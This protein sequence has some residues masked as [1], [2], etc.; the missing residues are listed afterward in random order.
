MIQPAERGSVSHRRKSGLLTVPEALEE[1]ASGRMVIV[2]DDVDRENEGDLVASAAD[3]TAETINFMASYGRGL[4]CVSLPEERLKQLEIP[5]MVNTN[6]ALYGTAFGVSVDFRQPG[7]TGISA[8]DR[9][10]TIRALCDLET[11]PSDLARPGH[12]FPLRAE[13]GGVLKRA[14]HTEAAADLARMAGLAPAAVLCEILAED[15]TMARLPQLLAFSQRHEIPIVT[16]ADLIAYRQANQERLI[17]R[18]AEAELPTTRGAFRVIG[19]RSL[20]DGSD[21]IAIVRGEVAG[22]ENVLVR[23]HSQCLTGDVFGS[24]RCDC[25]GQLSTALERI[26]SED[27]GVILYIMGHEGRG[28][29]LLHKIR[30]YELQDRGR[31]TVEANLELGFAPDMR[32]YGVGAQVLSDLGLTS[33]R[34]MTNNPDKHAGLAGHGLRIVERIPLLVEPSSHNRAYLETKRAKL[35]HLIDATIDS[36]GS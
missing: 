35:A 14:G 19:Y 1:I 11:R 34:L 10:H 12:V 16:V 4:V 9:A 26:Q 5:L 17:Q 31:D 8:H 36:H 15:G 33:I 21:Y 28:I 3:V 20:V 25:G 29:G 32:D 18:I 24:C 2:V 22:H 23:V 7:R 13:S 6:T 30:A 27:R